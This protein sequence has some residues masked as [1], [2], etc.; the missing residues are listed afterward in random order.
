MNHSFEANSNQT[1]LV[2]NQQPKPFFY[3]P[4]PIRQM[5]RQADLLDFFSANPPKFQHLGFGS[6]LGAFAVFRDSN[7][8][9]FENLRISCKEK[10]GFP[11][12]EKDEIMRLA[13]IMSPENLPSTVETLGDQETNGIENHEQERVSKVNLTLKPKY[14]ESECTLQFSNPTTS[15]STR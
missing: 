13:E 11:F 8:S 12:E 2:T 15:F 4:K 6:K 9:Q 7:T 10:Q 1:N 3:K 5:G 14:A